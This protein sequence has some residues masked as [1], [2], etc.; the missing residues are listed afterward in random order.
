MATTAVNNSDEAA[1][2]LHAWVA[3]PSPDR[4]FLF[5]DG[6]AGSGKS[7][8]LRKTA[9]AAPGACVVDAAGLS[10]EEVLDEVMRSLGVSYGDYRSAGFLAEEMEEQDPL[11]SLVLVTNTQ[12]AGRTRSTTEPLHTAEHLAGTLGIDFRI[13]GV[14]FVIEIDST[15]RDLGSRVRRPLVLA[16]RPGTVRRTDI[17]TLSPRW[18]IAALA[19]ALA[20]PREIRFTEWQMLCSA[21]GASFTYGELHTVAAE[22]PFATTPE[23]DTPVTLAHHS[24]SRDLRAEVSDEDFRAFETAV[25]DRLLTCAENDGLADYR[26]RALPAHA[27]AAGRFEELLSLPRALAACHRSALIEALP[28]AFPDG[29][30]AGT[31]AADLHYLDGLGLAPSSHAEWISVLH[32]VALSQGRAERA[33]VLAESAGVLPWRTVWSNWRAPGCLTRQGPH[34][35]AV[36]RVG[37]DTSTDPGTVTSTFTAGGSAIWDAATGRPVG[38]DPRGD[39]TALPPTAA[40]TTAPPLW[41][42]DAPSWNLLRLGLV[43][44]P[45]VRRTVQAPSVRDAACAGSLVI[46][47]GGRGLYAIEPDLRTTDGAPARPLPA[48]GPRCRITPRPFDETVRVPARTRLCDVFGEDAVARIAADRLPAGLT[49]EPTRR[50]LTEVG[51]PSVAGFYG[52]DTHNL[53]TTGLAEHVWDG[54]GNG[55][56]PVGDGPF[57]E[58]GSWIGGVLLLDGR[59]GR[60]LRRTRPGAVDADRPGS[61]LA[62]SSLASFVAMVCLQWEYMRGYATSAGVDGA[63]L[64][65]EL[66]AWL[67]AV[68]PAAAATRNWGHVLEE[69]NF[70]CL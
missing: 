43:T 14:R 59:T 17:S 48:V 56:T 52:L 27:A 65:D 22:L 13:T 46:I 44:T 29:V 9:S 20:E 45:S 33:R 68:D 21:L 69:E 31:F 8:L 18:R 64:L 6:P 7:P 5:V 41:T 16:P 37:I 15:V 28:V 58:L 36:A 54:S 40:D 10:T 57:Y 50:F 23:G 53:L 51:F 12:W 11:H 63:D 47:A 4:G 35:P 55:V 30:P 39:T 60:V 26:A 32:L 1:D 42:A 24:V 67:T 38:G 25:F 49:H 70:P 3:D 66:T 62:G 61:P 34:I 19:L 2:H